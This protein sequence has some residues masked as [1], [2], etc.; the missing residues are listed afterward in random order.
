MGALRME[1][2]AANVGAAPHPPF[3]H[4]LPVNGAKDT[5]AAGFANHQGSKKSAGVAASL[6][7]PVHG[8][9]CPAGQ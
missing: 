1:T 9:K 7:L 3:R 5:L 4:L 8:E 6:F 2:T